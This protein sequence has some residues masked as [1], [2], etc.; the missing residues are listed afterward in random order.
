MTSPLKLTPNM[1]MATLVD[2]INQNFRQIEAES[3]RKVVTDE[4]GNDRI[5]IGRREDGS[6]GIDVSVAGVDANEAEDS[7][8]VMS[9][10]FNMWKIF[11]SGVIPLGPSHVRAGSV[12]LNSTN[13]G[14]SLNIFV[15]LENFDP[16][17]YA[18]TWTGQ[19][20][21][22][23]AFNTNKEPIRRSGVWYDNGTNTIFYDYRAE[24]MFN[25]N[26]LNIQFNLRWFRGSLSHTPSAAEYCQP[27]YWQ[28][29]NPTR[30]M[31]YGAGGGGTGAGKY[32]YVDTVVFDE[33][34]NLTGSLEST[35]YEFKT[36]EY[37][38]WP[39]Q[40]LRILHSSLL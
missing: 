16:E 17:E 40:K 34:G 6:Y 37:E 10:D 25:S 2:A 1:D 13:V 27:I 8:K 19:I 26:L 4:D 3:R 22:N 38:A 39:R 5:I 30:D 21:T 24:L 35:T 15:N 28:I 36:G 7:E 20:L 11:K 31:P 14:Y 33:A 12:T 9:S 29:A 18:Q 23:V 32:C